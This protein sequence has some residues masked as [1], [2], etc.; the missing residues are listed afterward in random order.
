M[1]YIAK[2]LLRFIAFC[3][4]LIAFRTMFMHRFYTFKKYLK[5]DLA[6]ISESYFLTIQRSI[7]HEIEGRRIEIF[8]IYHCSDLKKS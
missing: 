8:G 1:L 7:I 6:T 4:L 3:T 2:S 5:C